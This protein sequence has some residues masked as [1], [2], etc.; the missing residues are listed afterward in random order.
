MEKTMNLGYIKYDDG[1][2]PYN[3]MFPPEG[4]PDASCWRKEYS[5]YKNAGKRRMVA[6]P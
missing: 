5:G 4:A 2:Y 1:G 6:L 3:G